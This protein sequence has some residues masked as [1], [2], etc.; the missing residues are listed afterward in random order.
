ML[1]LLRKK[2][3]KEPPDSALVAGVC[4]E[5]RSSEQDGGREG[6]LHGA[7]SIQGH[8][9]SPEPAAH[10]SGLRMAAAAPGVAP[11]PLHL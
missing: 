8:P 1:S 6:A 10:L 4:D 11:G 5:G 7:P 9:G 3:Q 2:G